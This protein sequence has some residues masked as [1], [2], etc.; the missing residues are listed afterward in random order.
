MNCEPDINYLLKDKKV[1]DFLNMAHWDYCL[2][3][4]AAFVITAAANEGYLLKKNAEYTEV[5]ILF[6]LFLQNI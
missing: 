1:Y 6:I 3:F 4:E 5:A 2:V